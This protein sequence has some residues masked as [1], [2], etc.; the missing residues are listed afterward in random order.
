MNNNVWHWIIKFPVPREFLLYFLQPSPFPTAGMHCFHS[1]SPTNIQDIPCR[2]AILLTICTPFLF[3]DQTWI[4][5]VSTSRK[6]FSK[7]SFWIRLFVGKIWKIPRSLIIIQTKPSHVFLG[8]RHITMLNS[9]CNVGYF[10]QKLIT[11]IFRS[12]MYIFC[13]K[14]KH[15][16]I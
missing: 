4:L 16:F 8:K 7:I 5:N 15:V 6:K 12:A 11:G 1:E 2:K 9:T 3:K 14:A 10:Y 13:K